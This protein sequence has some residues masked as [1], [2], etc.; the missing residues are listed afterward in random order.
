MCTILSVDAFNLASTCQS[1]VIK[2]VMN[3]HLTVRHQCYN[4]N[5]HPLVH[6]AAYYFEHIADISK[7]F[8]FPPLQLVMSGLLDSNGWPECLMPQ[9]SLPRNPASVDE[10]VLI[11]QM[12]KRL[13][14]GRERYPWL[15]YVGSGEWPGVTL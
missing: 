2:L 4:T 13:T 8:F 12:V 14:S 9:R 6:V 7:F 11:N 15:H 1:K 3:V 10:A 5:H